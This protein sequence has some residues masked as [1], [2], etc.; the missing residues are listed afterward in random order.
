MNNANVG[1][2]IQV[3]P[4]GFQKE[5]IVRVPLLRATWVLEYSIATLIADTDV[6]GIYK[7][8]EHKSIA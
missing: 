8:N 4:I 3:K 7:K 5:Q 1:C 6:E 2:E